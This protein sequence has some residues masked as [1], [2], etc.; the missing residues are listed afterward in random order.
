MM[1]RTFLTVFIC[2]FLSFSIFTVDVYAA[3]SGSLFYVVPFSSHKFSTSAGSNYFSCNPVV[4]SVV[5]NN[6]RYYSSLT[7]TITDRVGFFAY[8]ERTGSSPDYSYSSPI[9]TGTYDF[10]T[11]YTYTFRPTLG[12][13]GFPFKYYEYTVVPRIS[14]LPDGLFCIYDVNNVQSSLQSDYSYSFS[15]W[16]YGTAYFTDM[17]FSPSFDISFDITYATI[18]SE[19][20]PLKFFYSISFFTDFDVYNDYYSRVPFKYVSANASTDSILGDI[21]DTIKDQHQEEIDKTNEAT[22]DATSGVGTLTNTLSS[23]E[24]ITMPFTL[25]KNFAQAIAGDSSSAFTFPSFS[26]MGYEIWPSYT[27]DLQTVAS[28]FPVLYNGLHLVSGTVVVTGFVRYLWR[29]WS[30]LVGDD[31]PE[32]SDSS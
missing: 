8:A 22:S 9:G 21:D 16:I 11:V 7:Y 25:V 3:S 26:M 32:G 29:K 27:F 13:S 5:L 20:N 17:G 23:W 24:I 31:M 2:L 30:L 4:D 12:D 1:R 6:G 28:S 14:G 10:H 18:S 19:P 15:F